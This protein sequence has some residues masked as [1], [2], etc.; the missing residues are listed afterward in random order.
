MKICSRCKNSF[1]KTK[2][3]FGNCKRGKTTYL[4]SW[5]RKCVREYSL[6]KYN[7]NPNLRRK[8][9]KN[10]IRTPSGI[11][12]QLHKRVHAHNNINSIL[13]SRE[14]FIEWY[15]KQDKKCIYC[16]IKEED[17][18]KVSDAHNNN[19]KRLTIDRMNSSKNYEKDNIV[20]ACSKCN[21]IK[22]DLFSYGEMKEIAQKY[23]SPKWR[24]EGIDYL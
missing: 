16:G 7:E 1:P 23:I 10:F 18:H 14:D 4:H 22:N 5:C 2:E 13:I 6:K 21:L 3:Y 11:Y 12:S 19:S 24:K 8:Y 15:E 9:H 17:L 20:L